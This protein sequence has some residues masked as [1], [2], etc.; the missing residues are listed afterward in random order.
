M[1]INVM[2]HGRRCNENVVRGRDKH[3]RVSNLNCLVVMP[4]FLWS[5]CEPA[6]TTIVKSSRSKRLPGMNEQREEFFEKSV[7]NR[8]RVW[9]EAIVDPSDRAQQ[10]L[11]I[12]RERVEW[13]EVFHAS[14]S[15]SLKGRTTKITRLPPSDFD[16]SKRPNGNSGTFS[17]SAVD[18]SSGVTRP[19]RLRLIVL[20]FWPRNQRCQSSN[21]VII[22]KG[23][24]KG[25]G[26]V[27]NVGP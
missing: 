13:F 26:I 1:G 22:P 12:K 21:S 27:R 5:S 7:R 11:A 6:K 8:N 18:L 25:N 14:Q 15:D 16:F 9:H 17:C 19:M 20:V 2:N 10:R 4:K 3:V 23:V 24:D